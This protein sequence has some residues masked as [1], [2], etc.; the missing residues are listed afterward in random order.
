[1]S[2]VPQ[3]IYHAVDRSVR[4][5]VRL[6]RRAIHI[7][8]LDGVP[9][10]CQQSP[11]GSSLRSPSWRGSKGDEPLMVQEYAAHEAHPHTYEDD[12]ELPQGKEAPVHH[13]SISLV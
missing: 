4:E 8:P 2:R 10:L 5:T 13:V 11:V 9:H 3:G 7:K 12:T 1:V 6:D